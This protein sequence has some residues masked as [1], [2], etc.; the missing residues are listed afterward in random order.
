MK[1][2]EKALLHSCRAISR[3]L[4]VLFIVDLSEGSRRGGDNKLFLLD[5]Y[6]C[7]DEFED[8][9]NQIPRLTVRAATELAGT[10]ATTYSLETLSSVS[11][12]AGEMEKAALELHHDFVAKEKKVIATMVNTQKAKMIQAGKVN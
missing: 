2:A 3:L 9:C 10:V 8:Y 7:V 6:I 4:L 11:K 12:L 5:L 1:K